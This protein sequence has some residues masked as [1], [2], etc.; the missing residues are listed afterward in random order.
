LP[1][2]LAVS[3]L[4]RA[5]VELSDV[6]VSPSAYMLEWMRR[7]GW[8]LPAE[9]HVVP[10]VTRSAATRA[11]QPPAAARDDTV[12]RVPFFRR[13]EERKG[14]K[15]FIAGVNA[16]DAQLLARI[17]L[18]FLGSATPAWPTSRIE[19][20]LAAPTRAALRSISFQTTLDQNEALAHL[21]E[22]GTLAVIPSL[23]DNSPNT[24]YECLERG[25]AFIATDAGGAAELIADEDRA[26]VLFEPTPTGVAA[27]LCKALSGPN[28]ARAA[29]P[30]FDGESVVARWAEIVAMSPARQELAAAEPTDVEI[31]AGD[32]AEASNRSSS[33]VLRLDPRDEPDEALTETLLRAQAATGADVVT[34][35][36]RAPHGGQTEHYFVGD[37]GALGLLSNAY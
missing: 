26:R 4:E 13:L 15:P 20:M 2:A 35:A 14:L 1:G 9:S 34:C 10:Y 17:E 24:V 8:R 30:S 21:S 27:A 11:P 7:H 29:S 22:P 28:G 23:E 18:E 12:E 19:T 16:L 32:W 5:S 3:N 6:V 33:W 31:V 25:I 36:I 37:P